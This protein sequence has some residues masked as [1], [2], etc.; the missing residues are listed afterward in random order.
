MLNTIVRTSVRHSGVVIALGVAFLFYGGLV[1]TRTKY[2]VFPEFAPPQVSIQTEAPGLTPEQVEILVTRP[3]ENALNGVQGITTVRSQSIQGL[4][5]IIATFGEATNIYRARQS[6]AERLAEVG[7]RLPQSAH[8][9]EMTPLTSSTGT[10]L[11]AGITL[12]AASFAGY[13][14]RFQTAGGPDPV[15]S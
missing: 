11:V 8:A 1:L 12:L 4:S 3:I 6:V 9:P 2:D 15:R 14:L 5:A 13:R 10:V 7:S